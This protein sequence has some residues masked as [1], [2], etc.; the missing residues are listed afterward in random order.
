LAPF[1]EGRLLPKKL[2]WIFHFFA[3]TVEIFSHLFMVPYARLSTLELA[4][5]FEIG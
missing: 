4:W 2:L 3:G 1:G 5:R